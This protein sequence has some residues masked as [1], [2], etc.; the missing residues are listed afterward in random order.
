MNIPKLG[1]N[2]GQSFI[3]FDLPG[4]KWRFG[5]EGIKLFMEAYGIKAY[6]ANLVVVKKTIGGLGVSGCDFN[7]LTGSNQTE[8]VIDLGALIPSLGKIVDI[9]AHTEKAFTG[10]VSLVA[11]LGTTSSGNE[12]IDSTTIFA[13]DAIIP[14]A[15]SVIIPPAPIVAAT[16]LY[17]S[18]TPGANWS[19]ITAGKISVY[20]TYIDYGNI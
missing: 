9:F 16:E 11:K 7:F 8:Q 14:G 3:D 20:V 1:S 10:A 6:P 12:L 19:L 4:G 5:V 2:I 17:L 15:G 13:A 18:V